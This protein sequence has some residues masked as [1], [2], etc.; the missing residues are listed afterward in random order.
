MPGVARSASGAVP[1]PPSTAAP[2]RAPPWRASAPPRTA[3][4]PP[5]LHRPLLGDHLP[6]HLE[7]AAQG[8]DVGGLLEL[9]APLRVGAVAQLHQRRL[10][11]ALGRLELCAEVLP[12]LE[13]CGRLPLPRTEGGLGDLDLPLEHFDARLAVLQL[14]HR[15]DHLP[16]LHLELRLLLAQVALPLKEGNLPCLALCAHLLE[17]NRPR[18]AQHL[19]L[20]LVVS[21]R[22]RALRGGRLRQL[23]VGE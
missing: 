19:L 8:V 20:G 14:Q 23:S 12:L 3:S 11:A 10:V 22:L 17:L 5:L 13:C 15:Q 4:A 7:A 16:L 18:L 9:H 1:L 21:L 2:W 6:L